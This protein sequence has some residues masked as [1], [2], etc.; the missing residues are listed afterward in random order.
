M[1]RGVDVVVVAERVEP[2]DA[3]RVVHHVLLL[4]NFAGSDHGHRTSPTLLIQFELKKSMIK[5]NLWLCDPVPKPSLG[6]R[7]LRYVHRAV[8]DGIDSRLF[9]R[10]RRTRTS[11]S[12]ETIQT[13]RIATTD[14]ECLVKGGR[15]RMKMHEA[16][17]EDTK[18]EGS[19]ALA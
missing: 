11:D 17:K 4:P 1:V 18:E 16:G 15:R 9:P 3:R 14:D 8:C 12:S 19:L 5:F 13:M 7:L 6:Q 10:W 2:V